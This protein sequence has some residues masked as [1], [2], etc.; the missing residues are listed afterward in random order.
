MQYLGK[1]GE[2]ILLGHIDRSGLG[3]SYQCWGGDSIDGTLSKRIVWISSIP[4]GKLVKVSP[5]NSN[6]NDKLFRKH[7][8]QKGWKIEVV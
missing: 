1:E 6:K 2:A 8:V 4:S 5:E 3:N 7:N